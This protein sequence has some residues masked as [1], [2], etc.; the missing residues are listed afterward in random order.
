MV[1]LAR[2]ILRVAGDDE[3]EDEEGEDEEGDEEAGK[4]AFVHGYDLNA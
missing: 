2:E 1:A 3:A 4:K